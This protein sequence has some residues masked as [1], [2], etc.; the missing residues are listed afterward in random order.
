[1]H[2][3]AYFQIYCFLCFQHAFP[4]K[5]K[6]RPALVDLFFLQQ[7]TSE[8][9][10]LDIE[11]IM[12]TWTLQ[13]GYPVVTISRNG[14]VAKVTQNYFRLDPSKEMSTKYPTNYE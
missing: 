8:G 14:N 5:D 10:P 11:K 4:S 7:L 6:S 1:M 9:I 13:M 12:N 2:G 3:T